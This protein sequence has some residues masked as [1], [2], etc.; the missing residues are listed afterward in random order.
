[1]DGKGA[2]QGKKE[3]DGLNTFGAKPHLPTTRKSIATIAT[4]FYFVHLHS[5]FHRTPASQT[6]TTMSSRAGTPTG[7]PP[8]YPAKSP[9]VAALSSQ[10]TPSSSRAQS[11]HSSVSHQS[12]FSAADAAR[13][14]GQEHVAKTSQEMF[15]KISDYVKSE[16]L[17]TLPMF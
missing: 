14:L 12:T 4:V 17:G 15:R 7:A 10:G 3:H 9:V 13:H 5:S 2:D 1:M 8:S 6:Q 11:L 16:M